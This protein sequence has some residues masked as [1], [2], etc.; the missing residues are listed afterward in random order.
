MIR[1]H[2]E[3]ALAASALASAV[4]DIEEYGKTNMLLI[5]SPEKAYEAFRKSLQVNLKLDES[6]ES[7][8][9]EIAGKVTV[10]EFT[11][12][13]VRKEDVTVFTI[14]KS[15]VKEYTQV[16]GRGMMRMP[17]GT[18]VESTS[19]YSKIGFPV[20]GYLGMETYAWTDIAVD[21]VSSKESE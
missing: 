16:G 13:Q 18:L 19:I 2:T 15:G 12:Y 10:W 21:I 4:V 20:K 7:Q 9:E 5:A 14:G 17:E 1:L 3:D 8:Q 11:I 6:W